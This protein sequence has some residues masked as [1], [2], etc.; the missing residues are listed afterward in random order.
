MALT[1]EQRKTVKKNMETLKG[2]GFIQRKKRN[3]TDSDTYYI[4]VGLGGTGGNALAEVKRELEKRVEREDYEKHVRFLLVDSAK[5]EVETFI[6]KNVFTSD[7]TCVLPHIGAKESVEHPTPF[8]RKWLNPELKN[9]L[10]GALE[11]DGAGNRRQCGRVLLCSDAA[12]LTLR[13]KISAVFRALVTNV[14]DA[15]CNLIVLAG[16]A[17]GTGSGTVIDATYIMS[18][19]LESIGVGHFDGAYGFIF[20]PPASSD[21][22]AHAGQLGFATGNSNGYA[23]LKEIEYHMTL[24][25]RNERFIMDYDGFEVIQENL[26]KQCILI[27]GSNRSVLY[28]EPKTI[29]AKTVADCIVNIVAPGQL[30]SDVEG[31]A[32]GQGVQQ[33]SLLTTLA[34]V[35]ANIQD[36]IIGQEP[37]FI[38]R[39]SYYIFNATGYSECIHYQTRASG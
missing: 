1:P 10:D 9:H 33:G 31:A 27:D 21:T 37:H 15:Q 25:E 29:A 35:P 38:P 36:F 34:D 28:S 16:I 4:V 11:G 3:V 12:L 2:D 7:E 39:D 14:P 20:L 22:I 19:T 5:E 24:R 30:Q 17:G 13:D 23:A 6:S 32:G 18:Q 26:F 8:M